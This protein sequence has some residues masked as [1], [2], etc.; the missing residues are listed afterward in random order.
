MSLSNRLQLSRSPLYIMDGSAFIYRGFYAYP[1]LKR[2]DGFLTN[3]LFIVLR[4]LLKILR[5]EKPQHFVFIRDGKGPTF[6]NEILPTYKAN[7]QKTPD[8]LIAQLAPLDKLLATLG[9]PTLISDG[10]EADDLI[11]TLTNHFKS[12][13][14][15]IIVGTDKDLQQCLDVN[16][17]LWD[18]A[19]RN[20][21]LITQKS[22]EET[23][24]L[25]PAQWADFQALTGDN[26]DNIPGIPGIGPKTAL[27]ILST[28]PT[29]EKIKDEFSSLDPKLQQKLSG[30]LDDMFIYRKLTRLKNDCQVPASLSELTLKHI[31]FEQLKNFL[32]E[33]E[34]NSLIQQFESIS[35]QKNTEKSQFSKF[36]DLKAKSIQPLLPGLEK[37][38]TTFL[39]KCPKLTGKLACL[40]QG[41]NW[42]IVTEKGTWLH[43]G[44][45][46]LLVDEIHAEQVFLLGL[47]DRIAQEPKWSK[48]NIFDVALAAY[49]L[50][51]E[52]RDYSWE[53]IS[54]RFQEN[55][56]TTNNLDFV[57]SIADL[58]KKANL[59]RLFFELEQPLCTVLAH[60][61]KR[62][63]RIDLTTFANFLDE[64]Q[65]KLTTLESEI[66]KLAGQS[67]NIRSSQQL[68]EI[69]FDKLTLQS[70][71]KTTGGKLST[72]SE[73]LEKLQ[74]TH[75]IVDKILSFR[76]L[77][78]MRSTYLE[79][80]PRQVDAFGRLHSHFNQMATA[81]GRLSSS[82]PNLQNIPVRGE[83]G[84]RMRAC[85]IAEEGKLLVGA[86]YSQIELRVL[87]HFSKDESLLHAFRTE[88]D[89]HTR[90][91]AI[92]K[93]KNIA[94]I[95][96]GERQNAKTINFGLLYGMG[97]QKL[98]RELSISLQEAKNFITLY[99][100]QL[101]QIKAFYEQIENEAQEK[102]Y[103][104]TLSG[105][106]RL[107]PEIHSRNQNQAQQALR[108]AINT[109]IQGSAADIIK[110]A[111]L[112][113]ENDPDLKK[114]HAGLILQ[115]HDE[116]L[117]EVPES[118]AEDARNRLQQLMENIYPLLVP[119]KVDSAIGHNWATA[120]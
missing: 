7:R 21:K 24:N 111:M 22:F 16:V 74:N 85:F 114:I 87:A 60:M 39:K 82:N 17:F 110:M 103:V 106:R 75:P 92:L 41:N 66:F 108:M 32:K 69:L 15:I 112:A 43:E 13:L 54:C 80:L 93:Q 4:T 46:D 63:I 51:P 5:E 64:V 14:P 57:H 83:M 70:K 31:D 62:G 90:T 71:R 65:S 99:F 52:E 55:L 76:S 11:A 23:E 104:L 28:H 34:F 48:H 36:P 42:K 100:E 10:V 94:D 38:E 117:L 18:P 59:D 105:R 1:D 61:E 30:H 47:K 12:E 40:P 68:A 89:I 53:K 116:L 78:K 27:K 37:T 101:P 50:N 2:S 95:T 56:N 72:A 81:T 97:P 96:P 73:V 107:L 84:E 44:S 67:F 109:V 79:P 77:E 29:L 20:E 86:D 19:Q 58:L 113:V 8:E 118:H 91:A 45:I 33:Y 9:V 119:L 120:H 6:R 102:G 98:A 26:A 49:L 25:T 88:Q 35:P 115:V 3:S